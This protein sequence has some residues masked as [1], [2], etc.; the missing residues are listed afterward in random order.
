MACM[1]SNEN[2][3]NSTIFH[4]EKAD[5][6]RMF[7]ELRQMYGEGLIADGESTEILCRT[8]EQF[9]EYTT[10]FLK[11]YVTG[12]QEDINNAASHSEICS[13]IAIAAGI[14]GGFCTLAALAAPVSYN[15]IIV[16]GCIGAAGAVVSG[17]ATLAKNIYDIQGAKMRMDLA[18][19][20]EHVSDL[21][22]DQNGFIQ[23]N[24][25]TSS[26]MRSGSKKNAELSE[27]LNDIIKAK[28]D[29]KQLIKK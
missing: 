14:V 27:T 9:G 23:T 21:G 26:E 12:L 4:G 13:D 1:V 3:F 20:N 16:L 6:L 24:M 10:K 22:T 15:W 8:E 5:L 17:A 28:F 25:K 18:K 19:Y 11:D 7:S 29:N 2:S